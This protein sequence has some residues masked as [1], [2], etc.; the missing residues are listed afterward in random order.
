VSLRRAFKALRAVRAGTSPLSVIR[1]ELGRDYLPVFH[2]RKVV[3]PNTLTSWSVL[4]AIWAGEYDYPGVVVQKGWHVID[5]G[6]NIGAFSMLAAS[7]G[8]H[9]VAYEPHPDTFRDLA[10]NMAPW[11]AEC[12]Q[13]AVTRDAQG[14]LPLFVHRRHT[15][16]T[17]SSFDLVAHEPLEQ[18]VL[19]PTV[20]L[21]DV[22]AEPC[23][24]VKIDCEGT[25]FDLFA[26]EPE[27]L[28]R[29]A[30]MVGELHPDAGDVA[31]ARA[32]LECAGFE[33]TVTSHLL[34]HFT[35]LRR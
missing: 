22:L 31:E 9:V 8:A 16:A 7:R 4:R 10:A 21:R 29:A 12:H 1:G 30:R 28:R 24:L 19:V 23:D 27:V 15:R 6:A 26:D 35:A 25:E 5:I 2:G 18:S 13:A 17:L 20:R 32:M 3:A 14:E 34:P 11:D 33:V